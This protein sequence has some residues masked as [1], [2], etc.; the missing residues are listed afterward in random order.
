VGSTLKTEARISDAVSPSNA[1][2]AAEKLVQD[3]S[4][5]EDVAAL[6]GLESLRLFRRHVA[7]CSQDQARKRAG[8]GERRRMREVA[9]GRSSL[10]E[11]GE[12]EVEH[13]HG[14]V[15][16]DLHVRRLE[17]AMADA[18][19]VGRLQRLDDLLRDGERLLDRNRTAAKAV[20][21]RLAFDQLQDE[22]LDASLP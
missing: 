2:T 11:P 13:F 15:G 20:G 8:N 5:R 3:A 1:W 19:V 4:E 9:H 7:G 16:R 6:I 17:V 18:L 21:Q 12:A 22:E 10:H 14:A